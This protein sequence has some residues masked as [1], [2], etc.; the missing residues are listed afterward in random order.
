MEGISQI[1]DFT[2]EKGEVET[3]TSKEK[4]EMDEVMEILNALKDDGE[5]ALDCLKR[6]VSMSKEWKKAS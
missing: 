2:C 6:I 3:P 4:D 1:P 5:S